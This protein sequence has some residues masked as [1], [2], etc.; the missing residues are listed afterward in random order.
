MDIWNVIKSVINSG[1]GMINGFIGGVNSVIETANK[2]PGVNIGTVSNIPQ[3]A[4]GGYIKHRPG[5]ILANIGEGNEDEIVSPVS[6]LKNI[7][8]N[9]LPQQSATVQYSPQ[10]IIQGN[11]SKDDVYEAISMSQSDFDRMM[12]N[13]NRRRQRVSFS[14]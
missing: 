2:V 12:E 6:K 13:Y 11:A 1:I 9:S 14:N 3:L 8:N 10:V 7:I 4:T 5:G